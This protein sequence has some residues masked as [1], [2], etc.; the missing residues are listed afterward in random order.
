[1]PSIP[2][3]F[4]WAAAQLHINPD[5]HIVEIGCGAGLFAEVIA[6]QLHGGSLLAIDKSPAML[7]K[8]RKRNQAFINSGVS[9]FV[10]AEFAKANLPAAYFDCILA[11]NVN[12]F[13]KDPVVELASIRSALKPRGKLSIFLQAPYEIT[14]DAAEP[15]KHRLRENGFKVLDVVLQ[16]MQPTAVLC[17]VAQPNG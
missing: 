14:L 1:M 15:V 4:S 11:F 6:A 9:A 12:F 3:R 8:A 5:D 10:S 17:I 16:P 7:E 2:E 13:W